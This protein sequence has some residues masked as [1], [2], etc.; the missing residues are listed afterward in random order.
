MKSRRPAGAGIILIMS[1]LPLP[2]VS[3]HEPREEPAAADKLDEVLARWERRASGIE[4][5]NVEFTRIDRSTLFPGEQRFE[6][7]VI[8]KAPALAYYEM[9]QLEACGRVVRSQRMAWSPDEIRISFEDTRQM[10]IMPRGEAPK[11]PELMRLP[12]LF[13]MRAEEV[14]RRYEVSLLEERPTAYVIEF[15]SRGGARW[16]EFSRALVLL[17][18]ER[19]LPEAMRLEMGSGGDTITYR[20]KEIR[21]DE[22]V[23]P[24]GLFRIEAR[25]CWEVVHLDKPPWEWAGGKE[26]EDRQP[27]PR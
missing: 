4:T 19:L 21:C 27:K 12:F 11:A 13:R 26:K 25:E 23:L 1:M 15:V 20:A 2:A 18:K 5:I 22:P 8:L 7:R 6:G 24:D 16:K 9:R 17:D 3:A 14:R 10:I